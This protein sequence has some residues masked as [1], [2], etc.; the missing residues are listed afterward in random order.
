MLND[1]ISKAYRNPIRNRE[2][3]QQNIDEDKW[4]KIHFNKL[5]RCV[6][7]TLPPS[8]IMKFTEKLA[9]ILGLD[10]EV[11][12]VTPYKG[13][14]L[15]DIDGGLHG[16]YV[17]CDVLECVSVGDAMAPLLRIVEVK[18]VRG[19]MTHI[20]Y[21]QPRY[22]P[23][24]KKTFDSLEIDIRDDAGNPIPFDSGKLIVTLHFRQARDTYFLG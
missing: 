22:F 12:D 18:G 19:E 4:P 1:S 3:I 2:G 11:I 24:Q 20:E 15:C 21:D 8:V 10:T 9:T 6:Y 13:D 23:L 7:I 17:Y 16:L 14:R 5:N